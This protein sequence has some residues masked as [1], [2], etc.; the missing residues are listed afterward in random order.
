[1]AWDIFCYSSMDSGV[2]GLLHL[3]KT[4]VFALM[5]FGSCNDVLEKRY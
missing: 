3:L 1:L 2:P 5:T 4:L